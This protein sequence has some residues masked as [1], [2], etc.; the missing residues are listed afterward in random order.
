MAFAAD[1]SS[2]LRRVNRSCVIAD[3]VN[4]SPVKSRRRRIEEA[5]VWC[6]Q[7]RARKKDL[8]SRSGSS[9]GSFEEQRSLGRR[10]RKS[11]GDE[12]APLSLYAQHQRETKG[13]GAGDITVKTVASA[14]C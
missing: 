8:G 6:Q 13:H 12:G 1:V 10:L 7:Q 2:R 9:K 11:V 3:S 14:S 5:S 4:R